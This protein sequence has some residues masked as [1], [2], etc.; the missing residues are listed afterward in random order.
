MAT[1]IYG[2]QGES[3]ITAE[4]SIFYQKA[5]I[6]R[7]LPE[8]HAYNDAQKS[9]LPRNSGLT[10]NWRK[11]ASLDVDTTPLTEGNAGDGQALEVTA[12]HGTAE[13]YGKYVTV[14]DK[15]AYAGID[16][17]MTEGAILCGEQAAQTVDKVVLNAM[18]TTKNAEGSS[19]QAMDETFVK[20]V[21][22]KLKKANARRF[23]DGYY[24]ALITPDQA[25]QLMNAQ[26]WVDAAKYGSIKKLLKGEVGELHGV[27]FM[28]TTQLPDGQGFIYGADSYGVVDVEN[29]AGKPSII[30]KP[31]ESG[32]TSNPLE[33]VATVGWKNLFV[34][35]VLVDEALCKITTKV[36]V[37]G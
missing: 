25:Y 4:Q 7:L 12:I 32:G 8:L 11:F 14:S 24:H 1:N 34:A 35:K 18:A 31:F 9:N 2:V 3:G 30:T 19:T 15:L 36:E 21:V 37:A 13:Q 20:K 5:L 22:L 16:K 29:G 17:V 23:S 27:R 28:E 26:G 6:K 33:L 10:V